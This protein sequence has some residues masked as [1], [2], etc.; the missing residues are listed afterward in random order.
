MK[1]TVIKQHNPAR[2]RQLLQKFDALRVILLLDLLIIVERLMLRRLVEELESGRI[3]R[4]CVLLATEVL[5]FHREG[6]L[7]EVAWAD[8]GGGICVDVLVRL[9]P[10]GGWKGVEEVGGDCVGERHLADECSVSNLIRT[11][12]E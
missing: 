8:A 10:I 6:L 12:I 9:G 4:D 2:P 1:R 11:W 7:L 3:E 5:D